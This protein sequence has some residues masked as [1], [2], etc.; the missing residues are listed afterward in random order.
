MKGLDL[1]TYW[2]RVELVDG[3]GWLYRWDTGA[4]YTNGTEAHKPLDAQRM[5]PGWESEQELF[6]AFVWMH[7]EGN[8]SCDCNKRLFLARAHQQDCPEDGDN[9][10]G[11]TMEIKRLTAIRPN[12]DEVVL[13]DSDE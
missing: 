2:V 3:R 7:T 1:G 10:C 5:P 4:S 6:D 12:G 8:Y 13:E 11:D 9:P